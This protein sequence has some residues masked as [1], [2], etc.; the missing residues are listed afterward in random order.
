MSH[1]SITISISLILQ[2][3]SKYFEDGTAAL[4]FWGT[5]IIKCKSEGIWRRM[6]LKGLWTY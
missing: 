3:K 4:G 1:V 5:F 6:D 2:A